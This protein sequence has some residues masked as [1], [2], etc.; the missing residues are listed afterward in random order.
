MFIFSFDGEDF[1]SFGSTKKQRDRAAMVTYNGHPI[2][3]GGCGWD[4]IKCLSGSTSETFDENKNKNWG[5]M[6]TIPI[7]GTILHG[8]TAVVLGG[9]VRTFG[10]YKDNYK[11]DRVDY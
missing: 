6:D 8:H 10:G 4:G 7:D 11:I 3:I 2:I 1:T 9:K 5:R